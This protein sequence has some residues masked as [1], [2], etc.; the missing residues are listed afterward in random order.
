[1]S[2]NGA[3]KRP[4]IDLRSVKKTLHDFAFNRAEAP[5]ER[6]EGEFGE[7]LLYLIRLADKVGV[8]IIAAGEKQI[9]QRGAHSPV[10]VPEHSGPRGRPKT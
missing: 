2:G 7:L 10:L 3:L 4:T 8:D 1:L 9:Q 5:R 6:L